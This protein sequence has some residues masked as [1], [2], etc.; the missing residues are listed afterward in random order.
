MTSKPIKSADSV[1]SYRTVEFRFYLNKDQEETLRN[2]MRLCCRIYNRVLEHRI[3]SWKRRKESVTLYDQMKLLTEWRRRE[4]D[5]RAVPVEFLRDALR[6]VDRGMKAFFKRVKAGKK[7][8]FPRFKTRQRYGSIEALSP[9]LYVTEGRVRIPKLGSVRA[10]GPFDR[11]GEEQSLLRIFYRSSGWYTQVLV[12][13]DQNVLLKTGQDVAFDLG[14]TALIATDTGDKIGNPRLMKRAAK[15]LRSAQKTLSRRKKGSNRR[16]KAVRRVGLIYERL[17]RQRRGLAHRISRDLVNRY[18]RIAHEALNV[19]GLS[20][21]ILRKSVQ[22]AA[23]GQLLRFIVYK[24]ENAGRQVVAVDPRGTSQEC[25]ACWLV[26]PKKLSERVHN[27]PCGLLC[28]RDHA[29]AL[30]IRHR[31]FRPGR[32]EPVRPAELVP[33]AGSKK[34]RGLANR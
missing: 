3:K 27:C 14:L 8:G 1:Q 21:G 23:W 10:R 11:V 15:K 30:V 16:K 25:P 34:R 19:R 12:P 20:R 7:P 22:D 9:F 13:V 4:D 5:L 28:D 32:G 18:D 31:A 26:V 6:R 2:W 29:A 24:A 33:K 17:Q